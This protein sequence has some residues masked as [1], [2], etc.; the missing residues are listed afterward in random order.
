MVTRSL[1]G[2]GETELSLEQ[3]GLWTHPLRLEGLRLSCRAG[4]VWLTREGD[5]EDHVL[6]PGQALQVEGPGRVVVQAL[7]PAHLCVSPTAPSEASRRREGLLF[8]ALGVVAFSLT[9]PATQVAVAELGGTLVGLGRALIAAVLAAGVLA[10]RRER[11]PERSHW[12]RL[13]WVIAGVVVGFPLLS[14]LA[15]RNMPASHGAVL[16]G[17]LPGAT[18]VAAVFRARERPSWGFW[19]SALAGLG[20]VLVFAA[21]RGAGLPTRADGLVLLAVAAGAMG[22]AEGGVL[23]REL[24]GWRVICWALVLSM[25]LLVPVVALSVDVGRLSASPRA[26]LGLGYLSAVSMFLGFFAWYR[27]M[28]LGGVARVGQLQ[29]AQPLLTLLWCAL[30]L[31]EPVS[32]GTIGAALLV[33]LCV[34]AGVR[35]RV[36]RVAA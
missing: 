8:G 10:V 21:A 12:P 20:A 26:W 33:L 9:L 13:A 15:L 35:S 24:G 16:V 7:R 4:L 36:R 1:M 3:G 19:L 29:L 32:P 27:G 5:R 17:L 23:A 28:A 22:Y 25:P 2:G 34:F 14:A 18:A 6:K 30:L 31:G 11:L